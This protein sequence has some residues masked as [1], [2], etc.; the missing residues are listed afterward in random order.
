MERGSKMNAPPPVRELIYFFEAEGGPSQETVRILGQTEVGLAV[1]Q[2]WRTALFGGQL[3]HRLKELVRI[4]LSILDPECS[5]RGR[6]EGI[7]N[8]VLAELSEYSGSE[9]FSEREKVALQYADWF[10]ADAVN[11]D[12]VFATLRTAFSDEEIIELGK[13]C[14]LVVGMER[15]LASVSQ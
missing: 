9:R 14:A 12:H 3:P 7:T 13:F 11:G 4:R 15:F 6:A 1:L 5:Q 10:E 2:A 8:E